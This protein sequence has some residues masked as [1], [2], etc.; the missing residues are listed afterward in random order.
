MLESLEQAGEQAGERTHEAADR[1]ADTIFALSTVPGRSGVAVV[2]LSGPQAGPALERLSR[3]VLPPARHAT[4]A[5]LADPATGAPIDQAL[6]L[7]FPGPA[8]FTGEDLAELHLHGG[9]AV[10]AAALEALARLPGCRLAEPGEFARRAFDHGKLDLAEVEGLADLIEAETEAQR[11]QALRQ[12]GGALTRRVEAWRDR[13]LAALAHVEAEIDFADEDLPGGLAAGARCELQAVA[14]EIAAAL[15]DGRR[16][17]RLRDGLQIAILGPPN[18]GKSSL[19]NALARR[20]VAIVAAAAGTTRDV[21][22]LHLE[23]VG[24]P[25]TLADTAGL[26]DLSPVEGDSAMAAIEAEG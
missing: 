2:R 18:A 11:L 13:L 21:V 16:G 8:S 22:E 26:R 1:A 15:S 24:Y 10:R 19:L 5:R 6:L 4:L 25:V 9:R 3:R 17:E 20:D 14:G 7:W 12:M 23:L